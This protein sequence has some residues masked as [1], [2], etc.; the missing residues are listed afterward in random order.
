MSDLSLSDIAGRMADIDVAILS[1]HGEGGA[2]ASR[3]MSNNGQVD[4]DAT[5]YYFTNER[6]GAATDIE[7]DNT[8][9]LGF[10]G[11]NGFYLAVEGVAAIVRDKSRF[12]EHWT[13]SLDAWFPEGK[14]TPGVVMLEIEPARLH[15]WDGREDGEITL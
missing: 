1:T 3:P 8:V 5:S 7:R 12:A 4:L 9:A 13:P 15:Y 10:Q 6:S 2:I 11:A 14:D